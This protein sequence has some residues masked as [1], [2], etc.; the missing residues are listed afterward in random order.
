MTVKELYDQI[1][2]DYDDIMSRMM[3][4]DRVLKFAKMFLA[5]DSF[6]KLKEAIEN[7]DVDGA[8][9]AA[10]TLKGITANLGFAKLNKIANEITEE[11]RNG[12][13]FEKAKEMLPEVAAIYQIVI[14]GITNYTE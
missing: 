2:G 4:E 8:F 6:P 10:H 11:L 5:D 7:N 9:R 14:D 13:D 1:G 3:K 12:K